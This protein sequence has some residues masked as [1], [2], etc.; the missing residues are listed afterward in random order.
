MYSCVLIPNWISETSVLMPE[1][2]DYNTVSNNLTDF[3][4]DILLH[5]YT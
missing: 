1:K 4:T 5:E 2:T 3:S